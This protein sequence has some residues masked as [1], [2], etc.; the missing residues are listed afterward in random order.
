MHVPS[1]HEDPSVLFNCQELCA[2]PDWRNYDRLKIVPQRDASLR[3]DET[4]MTD[5]S[6]DEATSWCVMGRYVSEDDWDPITDCESSEDAD[7]IIADLAER[8][9]LPIGD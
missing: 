4:R 1:V 6:P 9:G 2:E 8:S 3:A 5:C 7:W